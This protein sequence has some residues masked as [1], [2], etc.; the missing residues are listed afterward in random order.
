MPEKHIVGLHQT[1]NAHN[2]LV[3]HIVAGFTFFEKVVE[4]VETQREPSETQFGHFLHCAVFRFLA[5]AFASGL[6]L[7]PGEEI[8]R[9]VVMFLLVAVFFATNKVKITVLETEQEHVGA[10]VVGGTLDT[11]HAFVGNCYLA[12]FRHR[13][14]VGTEQS[15]ATLSVAEIEGKIGAVADIGIILIYSDYKVF[16][17]VLVEIAISRNQRIAFLGIKF[18]R[19]LA[20]LLEI[21]CVNSFGGC[22]G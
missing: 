18:G 5:L 1:E 19:G 22:Q 11:H 12:A 15:V 2:G 6:Y 13:G 4:H 3:F 10:V 14:V 7:L 16:F 17:A 21:L 9:Y 20:R 8:V